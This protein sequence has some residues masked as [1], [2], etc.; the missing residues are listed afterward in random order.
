MPR[1][2]AIRS[3]KL[4]RPD[5][6]QLAVYPNLAPVLTKA[7]DWDLIRQQYD[8]LLKYVT[9][10]RLGTANAESILRR[11]TRNNIQHPTYRA[12]AELGKAVKTIFLCRYLHSVR[13][14]IQEGLNLTSPIR[15]FLD[16]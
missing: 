15:A 11:F 6:G 3:Q 16:T 9:A 8:Q 2:K 4:Y 7:I 1:L 14:E 12:F 5:T 10:L 13:R